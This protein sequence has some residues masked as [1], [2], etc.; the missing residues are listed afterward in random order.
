M[1]NK[2]RSI[3]KDTFESETT[4]F[5]YCRRIDGSLEP[6]DN[7]RQNGRRVPRFA[8]SIT[9][10]PVDTHLESAD[11]LE[12]VEEVTE[13]L[14]ELERHTWLRILDKQ[15]IL[16]IAAEDGVSRAAIYDRIRRMVAKNQ[17]CAIWWR[18]KN[19]VN[20]HA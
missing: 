20:Q 12:L 17:Y 9:D 18:L 14:N 2:A 16:D 6:V 11:Y 5:R 3:L 1:T 8:P 15:S 13:N 7:I 4:Y 19:K 10:L